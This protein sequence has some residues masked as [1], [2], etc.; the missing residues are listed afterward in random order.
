MG[1]KIEMSAPSS[2]TEAATYGSCRVAADDRNIDDAERGDDAAT[3]HLDELSHG[4]KL[5]G[6]LTTGMTNT[7]PVFGALRAEDLLVLQGG[8][9]A[10]AVVA[11]DVVVRQV[12]VGV[13]VL[14]RFL[15]RLVHV[16]SQP[17]SRK[18]AMSRMVPMRSSSGAHSACTRAPTLSLSDRP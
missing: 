17:T 2:A 15:R 9:E 8:E 3:H 11:G 4:A 7:L 12:H 5:S 14:D 13:D 10:R 1:A 6:E 16:V 18:P